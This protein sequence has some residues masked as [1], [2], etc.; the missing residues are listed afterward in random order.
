MVFKLVEQALRSVVEQVDAAVVKRC[1]NPGSVL[2]EG[3]AFDALA[4]SFK[5]S[6]HHGDWFVSVGV[7]G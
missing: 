5:L 6:L 4:L 1:Q 2:V 7:N 3:Q